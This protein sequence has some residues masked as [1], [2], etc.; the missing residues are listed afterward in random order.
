MST[1]TVF[2][3]LFINTVTQMILIPAEKI[4]KAKTMIESLQSKNKITVL[5]LQKLTG[6]LKIVCCTIVPG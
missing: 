4:E 3:D 6:F 5:V 1:V 2:L